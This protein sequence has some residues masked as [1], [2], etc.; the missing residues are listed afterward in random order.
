MLT[1]SLIKESNLNPYLTDF[2][3]TTK[4]I[5]AISLMKE[6]N[7]NPYF[8]DFTATTKGFASESEAEDFFQLSAGKGERECPMSVIFND[9]RSATTWPTQLTYKIRP[10]VARMES[11]SS[12]RL[13]PVLQKIV[14]RYPSE[15]MSISTTTFHLND[16]VHFS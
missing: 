9:V 3:A 6:T 4:F 15:R 5:A 2:T 7:F 16:L 10:Q 13:F 8:A 12:E 1:I 11:W 14:P